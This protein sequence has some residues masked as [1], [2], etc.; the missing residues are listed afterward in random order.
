MKNN[1]IMGSEIQKQNNEE[2]ND[3]GFFEKSFVNENSGSELP[4]FVHE[5][6]PRAKIEKVFM[7][8]DFSKFRH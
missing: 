4:P 7:I 5:F 2:L 8:D 6:D 1:N 3:A